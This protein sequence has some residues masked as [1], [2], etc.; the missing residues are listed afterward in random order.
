MSKQKNWYLG[1]FFEYLFIRNHIIMRDLICYSLQVNKNVEFL[2][3][4]GL[5][6]CLPVSVEMKPVMNI[7]IKQSYNEYTKIDLGISLTKLQSE[8][9]DFL[10]DIRII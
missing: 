6:K 8:Y 2:G 9:H 10:I 5:L 3:D 1:F 4:K 7:N